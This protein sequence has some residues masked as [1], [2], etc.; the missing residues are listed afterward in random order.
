MTV[1]TPLPVV[2]QVKLSEGSHITVF[3]KKTNWALFPPPGRFSP[4]EHH[5]HAIQQTPHCPT[6]GS[7]KVLC[8]DCRGFN[9]QIAEDCDF[10]SFLSIDRMMFRYGAKKSG[11]EIPYG[12]AMMIASAD[13]PTI[14]F[15]APP[16]TKH[17]D[18]TGR[19]IACHGGLG[20]LVDLS[21]IQDGIPKRDHESIVEKMLARFAGE[22][23]SRMTVHVVCGIGPSHFT[24]PTDH[25]TWGDKNAKLIKYLKRRFPDRGESICGGGPNGHIDLRELITNQLGEHGIKRSQVYWDNLDTYRDKRLHSHQ[26]DTENGDDRHHRNLVLITHWKV[27][28]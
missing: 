16:H 5:D 25:P 20:E 1:S 9:A 18:T 15:H 24:R 2:S 23:F 6:Q 21:A 4:S 28:N 8:P 27:P 14:V 17:D 19:I 12:E 11:A 10:N 7:I 22:N 13:C 3:G 26:E